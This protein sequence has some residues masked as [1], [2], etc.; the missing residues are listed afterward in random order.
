MYIEMWKYEN[1]TEME[2]VS[3]QICADDGMKRIGKGFHQLVEP[4]SFSA[5]EQRL[6]ES[7]QISGEGGIRTPVTVCTTQRFSRARA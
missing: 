5:A 3:G 2:R 6:K 1:L 4:T 7:M